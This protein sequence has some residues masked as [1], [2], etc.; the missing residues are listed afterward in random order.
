MRIT[1]KRSG[2]RTAV[3]VS[4]SAHSERFESNYERNRFYSGLYGRAQRVRH[5]RDVYN[6]RREGL[7]DEVPHIKVDS[8]VFIVALQEMERILQYMRD[9]QPKI[10][11]KA[12]QVMLEPDELKMLEKGA[13]E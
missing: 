3:L 9:W 12:F 5:G 4:F 10:E 8:S 6:Y 2:N 7:L 1:I 13:E 11:Y